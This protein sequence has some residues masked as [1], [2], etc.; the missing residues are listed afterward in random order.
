MEKLYHANNDQERKVRVGI[1]M[2]DEVDFRAKKTNAGDKRVSYNNKWA[3][4]PRSHCNPKCV[5]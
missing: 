2:S 4:P 3:N 1:L 5:N